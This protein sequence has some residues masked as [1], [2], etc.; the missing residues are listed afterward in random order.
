[1]GDHTPFILHHTLSGISEQWKHRRYSSLI[2]HPPHCD[3]SFSHAL[4][5]LSSI[6]ILIILWLFSDGISGWTEDYDEKITV[7]K[8]V[9]VRTTVL[10]TT[11]EILCLNVSRKNQRTDR[12]STSLTHY[13]YHKL[14]MTS[15]PHKV[16]WK[17]NSDGIVFALT[18][19]L[20]QSS[21]V[22]STDNRLFIS[23]VP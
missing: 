6:R 5:L 23:H 15:C 14:A 21:S 2:T 7:G 3:L 8:R 1:M 19:H 9:V 16:I 17:K 18:T 12:V 10:W 4:S 22:R 11:V 13:H 20:Q